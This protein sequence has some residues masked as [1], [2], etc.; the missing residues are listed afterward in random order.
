M[1][2]LLDCPCAVGA[3]SQR[4]HHDKTSLGRA[5]ALGMAMFV[6][7][8][9]RSMQRALTL[10][11]V[12]YYHLPR[13]R[14]V[15]HPLG[16]GRS[17]PADATLSAG[18]IA[19]QQVVLCV[20]FCLFDGRN[21]CIIKIMLVLP[22]PRARLSKMEQHKT[23]RQH[24]EQYYRAD[25]PFPVFEPHLRGCNLFWILQYDDVSIP[26]QT[27][28]TGLTAHLAVHCVDDDTFN[29]KD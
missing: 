28:I 1:P 18:M 29:I 15:V 19:I 21:F 8:P 14:R 16:E 9:T 20:V 11:K 4:R 7:A 2:G 22:G 23:R 24:R 10:G 17:A 3:L 5:D 12:A 26:A 25:L 6:A 27:S 13:W